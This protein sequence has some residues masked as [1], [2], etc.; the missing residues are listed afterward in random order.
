[1]AQNLTCKKV[2]KYNTTHVTKM[3]RKN[4]TKQTMSS[5]NLIPGVLINAWPED[6][7]SKS[8]SHFMQSVLRRSE[9]QCSAD[10]HGFPLDD[11]LEELFLN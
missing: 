3:R 1:M 8:K 4:K 11:K 2:N 5:N 7:S 9:C 6:E 10:N